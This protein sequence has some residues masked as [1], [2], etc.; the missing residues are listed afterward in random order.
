MRR[1]VGAVVRHVSR[2]R[3]LLTLAERVLACYDL[4]G[5]SLTLVSETANAIFHVAVPNGAEYASSPY[6]DVPVRHPPVCAPLYVGGILRH[7]C[8]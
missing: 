5:A 1:E 6:A 4:Y 7:K 8:T 2:L 3:H